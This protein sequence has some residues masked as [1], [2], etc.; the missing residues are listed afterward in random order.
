M[1]EAVPEVVA[2]PRSLGGRTDRPTVYLEHAAGMDLGLFA[3]IGEQLQMSRASACA[4]T[5]DTS[6]SGRPAPDSPCC[7]PAFTSASSGRMTR[8]CPSW[9]AGFRTRLRPRSPHCCASS[10]PPPN[11]GYPCT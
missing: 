4:S 8:D 7:T 5:P 3:G 10:T 6:G 1:A 11:S 9:W 2:A